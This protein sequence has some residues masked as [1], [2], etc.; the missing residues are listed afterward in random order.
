MIGFYIITFS[1]IIL[2]YFLSF[3]GSYNDIR[4]DWGRF[5][6]RPDVMLL[7]E[8]YGHR[9]MENLE[10]CLKDGFDKRSLQVVKP[11][12]THMGLFT[13]TLINMLSGINSIR[14]TFATIVG[15]VSQV[16]S[17]F[18][19]R[20]KE[21]F[22]HVRYSATRITY[23]MK[24]VYGTAYAIMHMGTSGIQASI[25]FSQTDLVQFLMMFCF[26]PDTLIDLRGKGLV[27]IRMARIGDICK[28]G[29]RI[30]SVFQFAADGERMVYLKDIL[31]SGNHYVLYNNTWV[32]AKDHPDAFPTYSWRGGIH[33][34][35][36]CLNTDTHVIP[37]ESYIFRDY[38]E[39][40]EG[41]EDALRW[42]HKA[43]NSASSSYTPS[44]NVPNTTA[45]S[46]NVEIVLKDGTCRP[47]K[48]I[49][50]GEELSHGRVLGLVQK[51]TSET[52]TIGEE[53]FASG[54]AVWDSVHHKWVRAWQLAPRVFHTKP[55]P[56][57]SFVVTP[58]ASIETDNGLM[59]RDYLEVHSPDIELPY[60]TSLSSSTPGKDLYKPEA[61]PEC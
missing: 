28:D 41:D 5:R 57:Y 44:S 11:F 46:P 1:F 53:T 56:F 37:I 33:R 12:Y 14:M 23:L 32:Q 52:C 20:L 30:T 18:W 2:L 15:S 6:C 27:P 43:L 60:S 17:E 45:F 55:I 39:T 42:V 4:K 25:N 19:G 10:F 49:R 21:L 13:D 34:P 61:I 47:A 8:F 31:V 29:S 58:S 9:A 16:F 38:D 35:L 3:F 50:L 54:T 40:E 51:E 59:I 22:F 26:D 48:S 36:I 7:A 24:R